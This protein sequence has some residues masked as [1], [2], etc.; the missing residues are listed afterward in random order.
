MKQI[1][2]SHGIKYLR[3]KGSIILTGFEPEIVLSS[4]QTLIEQHR[5]LLPITILQTLPGEN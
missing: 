5:L 4:V 1:N 2:L 3:Y